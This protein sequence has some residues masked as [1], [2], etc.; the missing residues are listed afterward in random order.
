MPIMRTQTSPTRRF[1]LWSV[2]PWI[3]FL[4][5][6][7]GCLQYFQHGER[8]YLIG[9]VVVMLISGGAILRLPW[10]RPSLQILSVLLAIWS[11]VTAVLMFRQWGGFAL[12]RQQALAEPQFSE[13]AVWLVDRAQRTWEVGLGLKIVAIPLLL[14]LAWQ[15]GRPVVR[16]QFKARR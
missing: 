6:A 8:A 15:L 14:W 12:A 7:L 9:A 10:A 16:A 4:L 5:A 2:G 11:L 1:A 3:L 13:L